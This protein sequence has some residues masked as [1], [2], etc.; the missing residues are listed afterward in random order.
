M[1]FL[2]DFT[3]FKPQRSPRKPLKITIQ[4]KLH[5]LHSPAQALPLTN[6]HRNEC[7]DFL[8]QRSYHVVERLSYIPD[9]R[10][11]SC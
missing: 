5:S 7:D 10:P 2:N 1:T 3:L 11:H 4:R 9:V 6:V 8:P